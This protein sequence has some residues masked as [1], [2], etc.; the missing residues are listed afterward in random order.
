[1]MEKIK[2]SMKNKGSKDE[3]MQEILDKI[4]KEEE[5][6]KRKE[7]EQG[8]SS[9]GSG[10]SEGSEDSGSGSDEKVSPLITPRRWIPSIY[11]NNRKLM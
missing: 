5:A 9:S 1:M 8:G 10:D 3:K 11:K 6:K 2:A 7:K 4:V